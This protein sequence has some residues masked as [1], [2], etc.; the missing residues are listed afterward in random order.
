MLYLI[1]DVYRGKKIAFLNR[2]KLFK[3]EHIRK[4]N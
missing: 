1:F 3:T 2:E 4:Y